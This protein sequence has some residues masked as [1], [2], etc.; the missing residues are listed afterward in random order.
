MAAVVRGAARSSAQPRAQGAAKAAP[1][2]APSKRGKASAYAPAKLSAVSRWGLTPVSALAIA[3]V[4]VVLGGLAI[5]ST[6]TR[7]RHFAG[8]AGRRGG[9]ATLGRPWPRARLGDPPRIA[10][11]IGILHNPA[12]QV[13][14]PHAPMRRL[15]WNERSGRHAGLGVDL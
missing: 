2:A 4:V 3:A 6:D 5:V 8:L 7:V 1:K 11:A 9:C 12:H 13:V 14:E 15:L 10:A